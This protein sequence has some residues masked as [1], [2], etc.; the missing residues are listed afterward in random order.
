MV[1]KLEKIG[2]KRIPGFSQL[3]SKRPDQFSR[4]FWPK[5]YSK[6]K[7]THTYGIWKIINSWTLALV[8]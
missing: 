4:E 2:E 1:N 5:Y 7:G 3:L 8:A 6:A